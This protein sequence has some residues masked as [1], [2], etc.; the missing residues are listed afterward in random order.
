MS[1][2]YCCRFAK[3]FAVEP[4]IVGNCATCITV[5]KHISCNTFG[6]FEHGIN[7]EPIRASHHNATKSARA[8][9]QFAIESVFY[10][11]VVAF[12]LTQTFYYRRVGCVFFPKVVF[13]QKVHTSYLIRYCLISSLCGFFLS[14]SG[15]PTSTI[16]PS[17]KTTM[18]SAK[19]NASSRSCV[20]NT[21]VGFS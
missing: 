5:S 7:V 16:L 9:L 17:S 18:R 19:V 15:V 3:Q 14:C 20:T 21:I 13:F 8:K 2:G 6:S 10:L 4:T 11:L 1:K 12:H